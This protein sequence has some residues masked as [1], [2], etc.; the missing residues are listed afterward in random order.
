MTLFLASAIREAWEEV[1]INPFRL[2]YLGPLPTYTLK[3]FQ[4]VIFPS[5]CFLESKSHY[6]LNDEVDGIIDMP[7]SAFLNESNYHRLYIEMPKTPDCQKEFPC[8]LFKE[9][10]GEEHILWGATFFLIM[11][12]L[13]IVHDFQIPA[14]PAERYISKTLLPE[15]HHHS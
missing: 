4:R 9:A 7:L 8:L 5:V 1:H 13:Q 6:Q 11:N 12:F 15:Y 10:N 3:M 2:I 14:I